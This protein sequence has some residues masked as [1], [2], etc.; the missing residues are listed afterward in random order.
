MPTFSWTEVRNKYHYTV[1]TAA[2]FV[3]LLSKSEKYLLKLT[4]K[5][6]FLL[7]VYNEEAKENLPEELSCGLVLT[8][9]ESKG[10]EFDDVLLF[11]F[12]KYSQVRI[13]VFFDSCSFCD[14][15]RNIDFNA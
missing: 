2:L 7:S 15:F 12:F 9:Y 14:V 13:H 10:L 1:A 11:N 6:S 4:C 5:F 3:I 8:I